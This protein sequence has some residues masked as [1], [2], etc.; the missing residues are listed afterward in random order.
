MDHKEF[1]FNPSDD[2]LRLAHLL[3]NSSLKKVGN[4]QKKSSAIFGL[5]TLA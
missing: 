1:L 2:D 3:E 5:N 4:F